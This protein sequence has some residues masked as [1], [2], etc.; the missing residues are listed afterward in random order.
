[1]R[2][3]LR[4]FEDAVCFFNWPFERDVARFE[5]YYAADRI[6]LRVRRLPRSPEL[7]F[8][9]A[10]LGVGSVRGIKSLDGGGGVI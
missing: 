7:P 9:G 4:R 8:T 1:M 2:I 5:G 3:G 10:A 6:Y